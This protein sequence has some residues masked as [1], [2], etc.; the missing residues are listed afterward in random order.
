MCAYAHVVLMK[1]VPLR[2]CLFLATLLILPNPVSKLPR[3]PSVCGTS[4][5]GGC[6]GVGGD[7]NQVDQREVGS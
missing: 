7:R 4:V 2:P 5:L 3:T 6:D 1:I